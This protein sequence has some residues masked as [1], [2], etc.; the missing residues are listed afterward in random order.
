[1]G[2]SE[3]FNAY[4][5]AFDELPGFFGYPISDETL[6][7]LMEK[8]IKRKSPLTDAEIAAACGCKPAPD[9]AIV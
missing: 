5:E 7:A 6:G 2:L 8:A 3:A 4:S 9:D 1:M